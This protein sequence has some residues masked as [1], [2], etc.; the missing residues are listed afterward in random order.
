MDADPERALSV[1]ASAPEVQDPPDR[2]AFAVEAGTPDLALP[3]FALLAR[4][5]GVAPLFRCHRPG[6]PVDRILSHELAAPAAATE[7][8]ADAWRLALGQRPWAE[9][10]ALLDAARPGARLHA[11]VGFEPEDQDARTALP[12]P[13]RAAFVL[14]VAAPPELAVTLLARRLLAA[15]AEPRLWRNIRRD[16]LAAW[17]HLG[18]DP[19]VLALGDGPE[20]TAFLAACHRGLTL[21]AR[22]PAPD[23]VVPWQSL[24]E[25]ATLAGLVTRLCGAPCAK[26]A[27]EAAL[28]ECAPLFAARPELNPQE[29][30]LARR[31]ADGHARLRDTPEQAQSG[32][33][34]FVKKPSADA[35]R[36]KVSIILLD[37]S[38]RERFHALDWLERQTVARTD[39]E[40]LWV[41]L[42]RRVPAEALRGADQVLTLGQQ[43]LYHKHK[44]YNAGLLAARGDIV[45]VCDSDAVFPARFVES[46]LEAFG[47]PV[48]PLPGR[49]EP[50]PLVLMHHEWRTG[51][52]HPYPD[53]LERLYPEGLRQVADMRKYGV[54]TP[55]SPNVGACVS[56]RRR[57][58]L[59]LGGFDEDESLRGLV[60]GP[61]DLAWRL[62]NAGL[63]Q[64]WEEQA[65]LWHFAHNNSD[66]QMSASGQSEITFPQI[67]GH[68]LAP[69]E[70]LVTGRTMPLAENPAVCA[71]RLA[72]RLPGCD[73]ERRLSVFSGP[74]T[75]APVEGAPPPVDE[76]PFHP[77]ELRR[78]ERPQAKVS[79][80]L[81][82]WGCRESFHALD[83]LE[84]QDVPREL[85]EV[86]WVE[87]FAQPA[88]QALTRADVVLALGQQG[89]YH[90]HQGYNAGLLA[91]RGAVVTVCDSDAVFPRG[92]VRSIL[93]TYFGPEALGESTPDGHGPD[94]CG[95]EPRRLVLMHHERRTDALYPPDLTDEAGLSDHAWKPLWPNAGACVSLPRGLILGLGGYDEDPHLAGYLCGPYEL[96]WRAVNAGVEQRWHPDQDLC[97]WHFAHPHASKS[98]N[99]EHWQEMHGGH[100]EWHALPSV[101]AFAAGTV[102]PQRE[103]AAVA[104]ARLAQRRFGSELEA[105][106]TRPDAHIDHWATALDGLGDLPDPATGAGIV[107]RL[108][109]RR[110]ELLVGAH[111][112]LRI[113]CNVTGGRELL[114]WLTRLAQDRPAPPGMRLALVLAALACGELEQALAMT[115]DDP[116]LTAML[117]GEVMRL[118]LNDPSPGLG[119]MALALRGRTESR[120]ERDALAVIAARAA[121]EAGELD[122]AEEI[123]AGQEGLPEHPVALAELAGCLAA[124]GQPERAAQTARLAIRGN[125]SNPTVLRRACNALAATGNAAEAAGLLDWHSAIWKRNPFTVTHPEH[126]GLSLLRAELA[127]GQD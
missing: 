91:S 72:Q 67:I 62:V 111:R 66:Q 90:K 9:T 47:L 85:F 99:D 52:P 114:D 45:T 119:Q 27:A 81:L 46:I 2:P 29:L 51:S 18:D 102:T 64:R 120:A 121:L 117:L 94:A 36:P 61:Y 110:P 75:Q 93:E 28:A 82:D 32:A 25:P 113:Y 20:T 80:I 98:R 65:A 76:L 118:G 69:M 73:V 56:V 1:P 70:A 24:A 124:C 5:P 55:L 41:E 31:L 126:A 84:R 100:V 106:L 17:S 105:G 7:A 83:W 78:V 54:W 53:G 40:I 14:R 42:Y 125:P 122:A 104:V 109:G 26:G 96:A 87:L 44:G 57:D 89:L 39:Y 19:D 107:Q 88:P 43:G 6:T 92:F 34:R 116:G 30:A 86:V 112:A 103:N 101:L 49:K 97:L 15:Q 108:A 63:P 59:G 33:P 11:L 123:L 58:A 68:A 10:R 127:G 3:L 71:A 8:Q 23:A 16:A 21:A 38:V 48:S 12:P 22:G 77:R 95:A 13:P 74:P 115:E 50:Q 4:Q 35:P 79:L 37:W 60:C